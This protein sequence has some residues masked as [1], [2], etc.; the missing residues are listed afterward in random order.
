MP[1]EHLVRQLSSAFAREV[2]TRRARRRRQDRGFPERKEYRAE[3]FLNSADSG[4]EAH[5][6]GYVTS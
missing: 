3:F 2:S 5:S 6:L 1:R 4:V